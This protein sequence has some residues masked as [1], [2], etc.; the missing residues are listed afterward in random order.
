MRNLSLKCSGMACQRGIT[1]F[2]LPPT[3]LSTSGV[4][5]TY[6]DTQ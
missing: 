2:Y 4:N 5:H 1:Q 6:C 3:C